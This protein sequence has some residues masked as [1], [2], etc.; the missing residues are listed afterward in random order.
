MVLTRNELK[1]KRN[2]D[3]KEMNCTRTDRNASH[4]AAVETLVIGA[5]TTEILV[6][7]GDLETAEIAETM[8]GS[9]ETHLLEQHR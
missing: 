3:A 9:V 7:R 5:A 6:L 4:E 8:I 2:V 1:K